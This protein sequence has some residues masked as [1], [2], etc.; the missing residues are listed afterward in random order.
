MRSQTSSHEA[1]LES[2][3]PDLCC[4]STAW[5]YVELACAAGPLLPRSNTSSPAATNELPFPAGLHLRRYY[6]CSWFWS[7][8]LL[9][10]FTG[11]LP[12]GWQP[13]TPPAPFGP[14]PREAECSRGAESEIVL[15]LPLHRRSSPKPRFHSVHPATARP[16]APISSVLSPSLCPS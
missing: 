1:I 11:S 3:S 10:F 16:D 9:V 5:R 12:S 6:H 13:L 4:I 15:Y 14:R 8:G 2:G 7:S